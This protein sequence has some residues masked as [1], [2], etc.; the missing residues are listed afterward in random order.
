MDKKQ[1]FKIFSAIF[2][3]IA[4]SINV[5]FGQEELP[6]DFEPKTR[7]SYNELKGIEIPFEKF[8]ELEKIEFQRIKNIEK[9]IT[10]VYKPVRSKSICGNG[11][12]EKSIDATEW[13]A[14]FGKILGQTQDPDWSTLTMGTSASRHTL[15][16]TGNDPNITAIPMVHSGQNAIRLGNSSVGAETELISKT[17]TVDAQNSIIRF[18][19]AVVFQDPGHEVM[20]QPSFWVRLLEGGTYK[21]GFVNLD[22]TGKDKIIASNSSFFETKNNIRYKNWTCVEV[23]LSTFIGKEV[24]LQF[25]T[26]DCAQGAHYGYAYI[27]DFCGNCSG[28]PDGSISFSESKSDCKLGKI[29]YDYTLPKD[30]KGVVG[31]LQITLNIVQNGNMVGMPIQS[32]MLTNGNQYCFQI[33]P[34]DIQSIDKSLGGFDFYAVANF[35]H[36]SASIPPKTTGNTQI[37][38][39][40]QKNDDCLLDCSQSKPSPTSITFDP[41]CPPLNADLMKTLFKFV[42][43]GGITDP[44]KVVFSPTDFFKSSSQAYTDYIKIL[45]P[46]LINLTYQWELYKAGDLATPVTNY[47]SPYAMNINKWTEFR[48]GGG[49]VIYNNTQF[50]DEFLS[51]TTNQ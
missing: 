3:L 10:A 42:P 22:G 7:K 17:F 32:P 25:I 49:G 41:C 30:T 27:D 2:L 18:W 39:G 29:C 50:W 16:S 36:P 19:Y 14:A 21:P 4:I 13:T 12:F 35:T 28:S 6:K 51:S 37:G 1:I 43:T 15:T 9:K 40:K 48:P 34:C 44:Y 26:E 46:S 31:K 38:Q 20:A 33:A 23:N 5:T 47:N 45:Y 24:T 11:G 8:Y